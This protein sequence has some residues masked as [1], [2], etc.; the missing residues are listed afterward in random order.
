M[1][2]KSYNAADYMDLQTV[3]N[4][5]NAIDGYA[6]DYTALANAI[7]QCAGNFTKDVLCMRKETLEPTIEQSGES[8]KEIEK[9]I[10]EFTYSIR[11]ASTNSYNK[12]QTRLNAEK[13]NDSKQ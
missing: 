6:E 4:A 1:P 9:Y 2:Q 13:V 7:I 5:C 10:K 12:L 3:L 11:T 8:I